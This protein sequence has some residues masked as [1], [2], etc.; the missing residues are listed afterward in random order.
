MPPVMPPTGSR[1]I[2]RAALLLL[3]LL[4][5]PLAGAHAPQPADAPVAAIGW[6]FEP[7]VLACLGASLLLYAA[8][9]F[10]L[11]R[12]A[13]AGRG[14]GMA[15]AAS[16]GAGWLA[17]VVALV[18]PLDALG[19]HLFS[20][21]MVQHEVLMIL[22]APLLVIGRPL[23]VWTWA[24]PMAWRAPAGRFVRL[25]AVAATWDVLTCAPVAWALHGLALWVWH[26]PPFFE[27][28]LQSPGVHT[29]QH[30][31]FLV[32]ALLFWWPPLGGASRAGHG[33]SML[34]LFT[35]MVHTGALGAL[36]TFST[37]PWYPAYGASTPAL[38]FDLLEDQRLG[39]LIM[40]VP[41][42]LA[43]LVVALA[44]AARLLQGDAPA[45]SAPGAMPPR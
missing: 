19:G 18:S 29:L 9:L 13:G 15:R 27:A 28:A 1:R 7:W 20:A 40:W 5:P 45:H 36:L 12:K 26:L 16:F 10:R 43:Y 39:G 38:G 3:L 30:A 33:S 24:L 31:S 32:T 21:H 44:A 6:S 8:G 37:V 2:A 42:G 11:W 35:T 22:A 14:L 41:A 4:A 34:Y 23:A 25:P 17:L